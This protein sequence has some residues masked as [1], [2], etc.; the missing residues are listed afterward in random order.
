MKARFDRSAAVE[1]GT[2]GSRRRVKAIDDRLQELAQHLI[3]QG[4]GTPTEP[5]ESA[6][7][8]ELIDLEILLGGTID[9]L[10][11]HEDSSTILAD[12]CR[13]LLKRGDTESLRLAHGVALKMEGLARLGQGIEH[14]FH[15]FRGVAE[16][17]L[18]F[19]DI[20][21]KHVSTALQEGPT[22]RLI[23]V[24]RCLGAWALASAALANRE[25][26]QAVRFAGR[27]RRAADEGRLENE[28]FQSAMAL[29]LL[30]LLLGDY[31]ECVRNSV[32][33]T[34]APPEEWRELAAFLAQWTELAV[35]PAHGSVLSSAEP[36]PSLANACPLFLGLDWYR[37][38]PVSLED[39]LPG[40]LQVICRLRQD[41]LYADAA[42]TFSVDELAAC[43]ELAAAWEL[44]G[45]LREI[46]VL[47]KD[48]DPERY[49]R[50]NIGRVLGRSLAYSL[51][52][53]C[54]GEAPEI[55]LQDDLI[56]CAMKIQG[57]APLTGNRS[58]EQSFTLLTPLFKTL[59][60]ELE[61][62]GG[63]LLDF[64]GERLLI[65]FNTPFA[66]V[67]GVEEVLFQTA[68]CLRRLHELNVLSQ[69]S[70]CPEVKVGIGIDQGAAAIGFVGGL[71][72][73]R[74]GV[75]G[76]TVKQAGRIA[77]LACSI[78]RP[79]LVSSQCF[80]G[81]EPEVWREP[82]QVNCSFRNA[83]RHN[84]HG[85]S[86]SFQLFAVCPLLPYWVDFVTMG[87][88]ASPE[89]GV[90]YIDTGSSGEPGIIDHHFENSRAQSACELLMRQPELLLGH[91]RGIPSS[92]IEF[93]LHQ[94]PDL[95]CAA[96]FYAACELL[97][98]NPRLKL[99]EK[100][101]GYVSRV[102]QGMIPSSG[103]LTDS[104]YCIFAAHQTLVER[105]HG[106][107]LT[108]LMLLEAQLRVIDAALYLMERHRRAVDPARIFRFEPGWFTAERRLIHEDRALY[109]EDLRLRSRTYKARVRGLTEPVEGL[110]LD[111]PQ[112]LIFK[113]WA[114]TDPNAPGGRGYPFLTVDWSRPGKNRFVI[115]VSPES[116]TDLQGLGELLEAVEEEKRRS[117]GLARPIEPRRYPTGNSDPWYFGWGHA[118]TIIDSPREGTV[119]TGEEVRAIHAGWLP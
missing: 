34:A 115:S 27:W 66:P 59:I 6:L 7:R 13:L 99:L 118:Y 98:K 88:A 39:I 51:T 74:L 107:G 2:L 31:E 69:Q 29:Q 37:G 70:G 76:G 43:A 108:D 40:S 42:A 71:S 89:P 53:P 47:L 83:G 30:Q 77:E 15:L 102:D 4:P 8:P 103:H 45:F 3:Q 67:A 105:Q 12:I 49:L 113:L 78:D 64:A 116:G 41:L 101:A 44:P 26:M 106:S 91:L 62:I 114:R 21:I 57:G 20:G 117:L 33:I 50:F 92:Q 5:R 104:L 16:I 60:E 54:G 63:V 109:L 84:P 38:E 93:R 85:V 23:S 100:L 82:Q 46:E 35:E 52:C 111:H 81:D 73:C 25:I 55:L 90:V 119:L 65:A 11:Q 48:R 10:S 95:D 17:G 28:S 18:G 94:K 75:F 87:F 110:W 96:T 97:R 112:S 61:R 9:T 79:V 80:E 86:N 32:Y 58:A 36:L 24:D 1:P 68:R 19:R 72:R 22:S 14:P 56:L